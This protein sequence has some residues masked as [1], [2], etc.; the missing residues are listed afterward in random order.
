MA[1]SGQFEAARRA[2][3][4]SSVGDVAL[5][6]Q[7]G[8]AIVVDIEQFGRQ[9]VTT[10][11]A[12][13]L[14]CIQVYSHDGDCRGQSGPVTSERPTFSNSVPMLLLPPSEG[15]AEGGSARRSTWIP[16]QGAF[17]RRLGDRRAAGG[18]VPCWRRRW[19]REAARGQGRP[20]AARPVGQHVAGGCAD[21][22]GLAALH[23]SRVGPP[24]PG[25]PPGADTKADRRGVGPPR[26]GSRRRPGPRLPTQD[27]RQP[28]TAG[29]AVDLVA[30]RGHRRGR[31]P[32][33]T[34]RDRRPATPGA[35]SGMG[36]VVQTCPSTRSPCRSSI[37][38]ANP[39]DTSRRPPRASWPE[40]SS[41]K[42]SARSTPGTTTGSTS[43]SARCEPV[44]MSLRDNRCPRNSS[45]GGGAP[46][47]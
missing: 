33:S 30:R 39:A 8:L 17:G 38:P 22:A 23:R 36:P 29:Q 16:D 20:P 37:R 21:V 24:R 43:S 46:G 26:S 18:R 19:R 25:D 7:H 11:V 15:K 9:R 3:S 35:S 1:Y 34:P 42:D 2:L 44:P 41:S 32:R 40:R 13:A 47:R 5:D 27:G 31:P 45:L 28:G 6:E 14:L 4:C 10:V 12:L